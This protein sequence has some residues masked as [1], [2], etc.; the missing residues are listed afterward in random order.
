M[1]DTLTPERRSALMKR[2][3]PRNTKPE[4]VVRRMLHAG[5]WRYRLHGKGLPGT[6][7]IVFSGRRVAIFVHGC[8]WHGHDCKLCRLPKT[9]T[10]F[11]AAK[12]AANRERDA[13]KVG[14][15]NDAGW[16]V[17]TVWQCSLREPS[18]VLN[19]MEVFL[20]GQEQVRE[21][22]LIDDRQG[23]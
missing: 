19:D 11:W 12:L 6:P 5:G 14:Q 17:M 13:R 3:G 15:L 16:R 20:R 4:M 1:V 2:V 22:R 9:R 7:D 10:E 23:T 8:F 21:T 18:K